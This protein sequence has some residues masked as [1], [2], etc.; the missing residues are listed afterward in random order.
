MHRDLG[1]ACGGLEVPD[2]FLLQA[3]FAVEVVALQVPTG[4]VTDR[5]G[6]SSHPGWMGLAVRG[7]V[8]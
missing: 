4:M 3:L 5:T 8:L 6:K 7:S 1:H 2:V